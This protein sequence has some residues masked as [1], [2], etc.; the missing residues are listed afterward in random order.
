[1]AGSGNIALDSHSSMVEQEE[2]GE[3]GANEASKIQ[4]PASAG[5]GRW[6]LGV[7]SSSCN[8][9]YTDKYG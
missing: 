5:L 6:I 3:D 7:A 4:A 2:A 8:F 1:M 9:L